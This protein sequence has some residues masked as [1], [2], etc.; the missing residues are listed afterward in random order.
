MADITKT[1]D[2]E[3]II[4]AKDL[5]PYNR[6]Y[7]HRLLWSALNLLDAMACLV[8]GAGNLKWVSST[9]FG[10]NLTEF[11]KSP[12]NLNELGLYLGVKD[13]GVKL[14]QCHNNYGV[15]LYRPE[16]A[17]Y[18]LREEVQSGLITIRRINTNIKTDLSQDTEA[19]ELLKAL[20]EDRICLYYQ[21]VVNAKTAQIHHYECLARMICEDNSIASPMEFIPVAERAGLI[22]RLDLLTLNIALKELEKSPNIRLAVNVSAAT[23]AD[24]KARDEFLQSMQNYAEYTN[25]M[26]IEITETIAIHDLEVAADFAS[27]V[28]KLNSR[29]SLDDFGVGYTSFRSLKVLPL[30]E[31][32][33]DGSYVQGILERHDN[34]AFVKAINS[35]AKDLGYETIAECIETDEEAALLHE[36]GIDSL[37]GYLYGRPKPYHID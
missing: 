31:V 20:D 9:M 13:L 27:K 18:E 1:K 22:A 28:K 26:T 32:K 17:D 15:R 14:R 3:V 37:Q 35:L 5:F 16:N 4:D 29:I 2:K 10:A 33:I 12:Q 19:Q 7:E 34:L 6:E 21:P 8:D 24:V 36:I 25:R 30:D 11:T 23:I